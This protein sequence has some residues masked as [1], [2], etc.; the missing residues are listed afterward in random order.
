M[1][2]LSDSLRGM[3]DR[4]PLDDATVSVSAAAGRVRR[5]RR[6]RAGANV[7]AGAGVAAV[8]ALAVVNPG[9]SGQ[10]PMADLASGGMSDSAA[11]AP[12]FESADGGIRLAWGACGTQ[13]FAEGAPDASA[14]FSLS[15]A[16]IDGEHD[17]G[18]S[19]GLEA[20]L[21][22]AP[23]DAFMSNGTHVMVMWDGYVVGY[24]EGAAD[25]GLDGSAQ[26]I[27]VDLVNCWDGAPLPGGTYD[28][29]AY[30]NLFTAADVPTDEPGDPVG[31]VEPTVAPSEPGTSDGGTG[32][33]SAMPEPTLDEAPPADAGGTADTSTVTNNESSTLTVEP[34]SEFVVSDVSTLTVLGEQVED[35]FGQYLFPPA[36]EAPTDAITPDI[37]RSLYA[38]HVTTTPWDMAAGTQRVVKVTDWIE[39]PTGAGWESAY[40]GC[41]YDGSTG[42][43]FPET[44]STWKVLDVTAPLPGSIGVSYGWIVDGNPVVDLEVRNATDY[45]LPGFYGEPNASLLLVRDGRVV[46]ESYLP[47]AS[48][49]SQVYGELST[50]YLAAGE[51]LGGTYLWRDINGCFTGEVPLTVTPGTYTV[52]QVQGLYL[53]NGQNGGGIWIAE[54]GVLGGDV[55]RGTAEGEDVAVDPAR[56]D[57][58]PD[59][60]T[61]DYVE[62]QVWTSLGTVTVS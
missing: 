22:P 23:G 15:L 31:P 6:L 17:A 3:A 44:S 11:V 60:S 55:V 8:V 35:P 5:G 12:G 24:A 14:A 2:R 37:A 49:A 61:Y 62:M 51:S 43:S 56:P 41:S 59:A 29:A 50:G 20:T 33:G 40:Y 34:T 36:P 57:E 45:S 1:T 16:G 25:A 48:P 28:I 47:S 30:T 9:G 53:D 38:E 39:D 27:G 52:L 32:D 19:L 10:S 54:D 58:A 26:A 4:A 7:T 46:A 13:P 42:I 18:S 21:A